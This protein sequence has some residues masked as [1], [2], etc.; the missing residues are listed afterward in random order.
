MAPVT[1]TNLR[2]PWGISFTSASPFWVSDQVTGVAT[3]YNSTGVKQALTVTIPPVSSGNPTGTVSNSSS[4][5]NS[6]LFLFASLNG[7]ING[8]RNALGTTAETLFAAPAGTVYTGLTSATVGAVPVLYAADT[9]HG[10]IDVYNNAGLTMLSGSFV[11]PTIP[12]GFTPYNVQ[13]I[14]GVIY[15]TYAK[16]GAPGGFLSE[17]MPDG[18][19]IK[20]LTSD[21]ILNSPWGI[22]LAPAGFGNIGGDLLIGNEGNGLINV[23]TTAGTLVGTL[24]D[25]S[26]NALVN[27]GLWALTFGNGGNGG[28]PNSLYL[29]A[30]IADET[31]GLFA[32]IDAVPEPGTF[33]LLVLGLCLVAFSRRAR[34]PHR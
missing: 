23:F 12:S 31:Q 13:N 26:G 29:T 2:N 25:L 28:S 6:D 19:F 10:K 5:F 32:R 8:W 7:T 11:D 20:R 4:S 21:A 15:V 3:L 9:S 14:A 18:T 24:S 33:G 34:R 16:K 30:G 22:A 17:F 1:D 27:S